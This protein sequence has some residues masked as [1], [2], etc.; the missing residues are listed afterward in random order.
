MKLKLKDE[1]VNSVIYVSFENRNVLGKF[2]DV[3]LYPYMYKKSPELFNLVCDKCEDTKCKCK[4][5]KSK[6]TKEVD[7]KINDKSDTI[8]G[9]NTIG[10]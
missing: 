8:S 5:D 4:E 6:K 9:S 2:I 3:K 1:Y 10:K 7:V